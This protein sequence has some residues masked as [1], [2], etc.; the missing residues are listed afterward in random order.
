MA[1]PMSH[2]TSRSTVYNVGKHSACPHEREEEQEIDP[3]VELGSEAC[4]FRV[5][6][7]VGAYAGSTPAAA[8]GSFAF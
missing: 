2:S 3:T 8:S 5:E 7:L 6:V 4:R 1:P